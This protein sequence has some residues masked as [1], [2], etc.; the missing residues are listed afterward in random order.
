MQLEIKTTYLS[1]DQVPDDARLFV[2]GDIHGCDNELEVMLNHIK[3]VEKLEDTEYVVFLGDYIDRG[4]DSRGV[5]QR[6]I[7]FKKYHPRSVFLRGNHEDMLFGLLGLG[8]MYGRDCL[9]NGGG[10]FFGNYGLEDYVSFRGLS[11]QCGI[12]DISQEELINK[13][14]KEHMEF[15]QS[16]VSVV[17]HPKYIFV[18]AGI[19]PYGKLEEQSYEDIHWIRDLFFMLR[20][21]EDQ[22]VV[23]GHTPYKEISVVADGKGKRIGLDTGCG[24]GGKLTAMEL[25]S[26]KAFSVVEDSDVVTVDCEPGTILFKS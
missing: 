20:H 12:D 14:P 5:I 15:L 17:V 11:D 23:H 4:P 8:G 22:I 24:K 21:S 10:A 9:R 18:H 19:D 13:F 25:K 6:L 7:E 2:I 1:T 3:N 16:L 26:V